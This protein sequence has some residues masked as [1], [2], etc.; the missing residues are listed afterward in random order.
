MW[1]VI[2]IPRFRTASAASPT[3]RNF[4]A[5]FMM[6]NTQQLGREKSS[7]ERYFFIRSSREVVIPG[8]SDKPSNFLLS[9]D[10]FV[11]RLILHFAIERAHFFIIEHIIL[12][13]LP[14]NLSTSL[15][16]TRIRTFTRL[17][18]VANN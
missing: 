4:W 2:L 6:R 1:F 13:N 15:F 17:L 9:F 12:Q 16:A 3:R 7:F 18:I 5:M 8:R 14:P 10:E 11:V